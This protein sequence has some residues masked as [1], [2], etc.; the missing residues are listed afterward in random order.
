MSSDPLG[1]AMVAAVS[2]AV[3]IAVAL[4]SRNVHATDDLTFFA[5]AAQ[6]VVR[7]ST[8]YEMPP[9]GYPYAPLWM[10]VLGGVRIVAEALRM[11]FG[12]LYK[13][14]LAMIDTSVAAVLYVALYRQTGRRWVNAGWSLAYALNPITLY[15]SGFVGQFDSFLAGLVLIALLIL[16]RRPSSRWAFAASALLLG[17]GIALKAWPVVF[18]P[19]FVLYLVHLRIRFRS[20]I[21]LKSFV[22]LPGLLSVLPFLVL[23]Q[24]EVITRPIQYL[25]FTSGA[26]AAGY[27]G[28]MGVLRF[29]GAP[30]A[31][32]T[33]AP[34]RVANFWYWD[35]LL[36]VV[37]ERNRF[38]FLTKVAFGIGYS[39][40]ILRST[41]IGLL[42]SYMAAILL[43]YSLIGGVFTH[44]LVWIIPFALY[45][46][47]PRSIPFML[48]ATS[49]TLAVEVWEPSPGAISMAG[50]LANL[51][52]WA[53]CLFWAIQL[54][55]V[56]GPNR[57]LTSY[58]L[59]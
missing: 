46:R 24:W 22:L 8:A 11:D 53:F 43:I 23:G 37:L 48:L 36:R 52:F 16:D 57:S 55:R 12:L 42:Q 1:A 19:L 30:I 7:G 17:L 35:D 41:R 6:L 15:V 25:V 29:F 3:R 54:L 39:L 18:L 34:L 49:V 27:I 44:Y 4:T 10:Y 40:V 59:N 58:G 5:Q 51:A 14:G 56:R 21:V 45:A 33:E 20:I 9:V 47:D 28:F 50:Y 13:I 32:L 2:L 38:I 26:G 31:G